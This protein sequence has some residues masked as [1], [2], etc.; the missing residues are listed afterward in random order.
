MLSN[1]PYGK[2]WKVDAEKMVGNGHKNK[3][4]HQF[5]DIAGRP[6][7]PSL[8]VVFLIELADQFLLEDS[9]EA[10]LDMKKKLDSARID[11]QWPALCNMAGQAF[12]NASPFRLR[13]LTRLYC[14][15]DCPYIFIPF[16][17][18]LVSFNSQ[19]T[20][21][22]FKT[23]GTF[24][25]KGGSFMAISYKKLWKLLIDKDMKKK[26]LQQLIVL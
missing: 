23:Q 5:N 2:S 21:C 19:Q 13:D 1:P 22:C 24:P 17:R 11:N 16:S 9:K 4:S 20:Y 25:E 8:F 12:C 26:D 7:F 3:V 18:R 15:F 6:V 10:V 14:E